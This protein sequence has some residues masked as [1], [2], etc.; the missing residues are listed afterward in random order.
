MSTTLD[1][2]KKVFDSVG[3]KRA[4]HIWET[5]KQGDLE[6]NLIPL[7]NDY[8]SELFAEKID[9]LAQDQYKLS[10]AIAEIH[11]DS[12]KDSNQKIAGVL[13]PTIAGKANG[14]NLAL[15]PWYVDSSLEWTKAIH[16]RITDVHPDSWSVEEVDSAW[17]IDDL[18]CLEWTGHPPQLVLNKLGQAVKCTF[19]AGVDQR[20][21]Y[22]HGQ[23]GIIGHWECIDSIN[24]T[25]YYF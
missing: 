14:D 25:R 17:S 5:S 4:P 12:G 18:G 6:N 3:S 15:L 23:N 21:D 2:Q 9:E 20:G 7:H 22:I 11:Y 8:L 10:V 1:I 13:Y 24:G 16:V 19:K